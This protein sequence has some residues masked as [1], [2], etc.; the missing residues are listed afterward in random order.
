MLDILLT[1]WAWNRGWKGLSLIPIIVSFV[2]IFFFAA[3]G[4]MEICILIVVV[5]IGTLIFMIAKGR[6]AP[7]AETIVPLAFQAARPVVD[8]PVYVQPDTTFVPQTVVFTGAKLVAPDRG[9]IPVTS[10]TNCLGRT[11]FEKAVPAI[12]VSLIS[13]QHLQIKNEY[14][15]YFAEDCGS[16]NGTRLNG[17]EIKGKGWQELRDGDRIDVAGAANLTFVMN[18]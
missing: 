10:G 15:R 17:F 1:I 7:S 14:G 11:D 18:H 3:L 6:K 2:S 12:S 9:E 8:Q 5:E 4:L 16:S 13:R